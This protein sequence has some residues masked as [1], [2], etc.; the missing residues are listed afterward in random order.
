MNTKRNTAMHA[1]ASIAWMPPTP[2]W[3][4]MVLAG[5]VLIQ[6]YTLCNMGLNPVTIQA[7][8]L[9]PGGD[10][11]LRITG[12]TCNPGVVLEPNTSRTIHVEINPAARGTVDQF[13]HIQQAGTG[14]PL[15]SHITF[16][17]SDHLARS[18]IGTRRPASYL[19][20]ETSGMDRVRRE[21]EQDGHRRLAKVHARD[22]Q[23]QQ[24]Q[25][26]P[27]PEGELQNNILQNPWLDSQRF[28]GIDPSLN[29]EPPM[30]TAAR[31][32]FDNE[33]RDQEMEKQLR[34]GNMPA[35]TTAPKP[36]GPS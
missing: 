8:G 6:T 7:M 36:Q 30:N 32:E 34:L 24:Q 10:S 14:L 19:V 26:Q 11:R 21:A 23:E 2:T 33:K 3:Q 18:P 15:R 27:A 31:T 20:D 4:G 16:R 13:L 17:I 12:G 9:L 5:R 35:F 1:Q 22:H 25:E 28:D 29:P